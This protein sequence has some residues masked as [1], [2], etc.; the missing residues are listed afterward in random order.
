MSIYKWK[1]SFLNIYYMY[2][3]K[4]HSSQVF[5]IDLC[6]NFVLLCLYLESLGAG[7][8]ASPASLT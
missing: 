7:T 2:I 5:L 4:G 1:N 3:S 6:G 8:R